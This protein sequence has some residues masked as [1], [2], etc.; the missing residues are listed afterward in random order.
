MN[1]GNAATSHPRVRP[2][3][4]TPIRHQGQDLIHL[5]D[6]DGFSETKLVVAPDVFFILT[7]CDGNRPISDIQY[8]YTRRFGTLLLSSRLDEILSDLDRGLFL[9]NERFRE[10]KKKVED[11]FKQAPMREA[12]LAG[13]AYP[14]N[15]DE[16]RSLLHGF[17]TSPEGPGPFPEERNR[18]VV[19]AIMAPHIDL[20]AGGPC[21]AWAYSELA[22]SAPPDIFVILGIGHASMESLFAL[23]RKDFA[24]PLGCLPT[25]QA[26]VDSLVEN[27]PGD[28]LADEF[29]HRREHSVEFQTVFLRYIFPEEDIFIVPILCSSFHEMIACGKQPIEDPRVQDFVQAIRMA[30]ARSKKKIC[31]IA[32]VDLAHVGQK[33]G[34]QRGLTSGAE[35]LVESE[36]RE[37]LKYVENMDAAGFFA[38]VAK[39]NDRRKICGFPAT[40]VLLNVVAPAKARL[41]KYG[42]SV[43]H[44]TQSM[45]SFASMVFE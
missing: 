9:D 42:K 3:Q 19:K 38:S 41:L 31:F 13:S 6:P 22:R 11:E 24:T 1:D 8:E 35:V 36:D 16:L 4:P 21:F 40:Y 32:G 39:D 5:S 34:D 27:Y 33:F 37:M 2:L 28:L 15:S 43:E 23:T 7:L 26:F 12:A 17:F 25:D 10:H 45:V 44:A 14:S 20:R 30:A 18:R 29:A